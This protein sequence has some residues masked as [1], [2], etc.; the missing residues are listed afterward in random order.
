MCS[1][2]ETLLWN[3]STQGHT[4]IMLHQHNLP[5]ENLTKTW[6]CWCLLSWWYCGAMGRTSQ[7]CCQVT[8]DQND[9]KGARC[10]VWALQGPNHITIWESGILFPAYPVL[11]DRDSAVMS[12]LDLV[13]NRQPRVW[14]KLTVCHNG[15][16]KGHGFDKRTLNQIHNVIQY[17]RLPNRP[18]RCPLGVVH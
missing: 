1:S 9:W 8:T 12:S 5:A 14:T 2:S 18:S 15:Q 7:H 16:T 10:G 3:I 4:V 17:L 13:N 11:S 6:L